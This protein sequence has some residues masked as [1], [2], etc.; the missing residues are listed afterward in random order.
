MAEGWREVSEVLGG[1]ER[2]HSMIATDGIDAAQGEA[3]RTYS[4]TPD[5]S[6]DS[7]LATLVTLAT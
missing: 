4:E 7:L 2:G 6:D 3:I 1:G 5:E